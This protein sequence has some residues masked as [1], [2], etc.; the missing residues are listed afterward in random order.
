M[1]FYYLSVQVTGE[2]AQDKAILHTVALLQSAYGDNSVKISGYTSISYPL[3]SKVAIIFNRETLTDRS[4][5]LSYI[6]MA[7]NHLDFTA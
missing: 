1:S 4:R 6:M 2:S 7:A 5:L 3:F